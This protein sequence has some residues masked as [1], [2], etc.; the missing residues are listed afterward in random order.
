MLAIALWLWEGNALAQWMIEVV[1]DFVWGEGGAIAASDADVND[2]LKAFWTDPVNKLGLRLDDW[3]RELG[4]QGELILPVFV[5]K[6]DGHVRLGYIPP[7]HVEDIIPDPDNCLIQAA[8]VLKASLG[9]PRKVYKVVRAETWR[10]SPHYGRLMPAEP[11]ERDISGGTGRVYDGSCILA[12]TNK[13]SGARRGRSDLL[14]LI[15]W[16][17]GYDAALFDQLD[18]A[19]LIDSF[20]WDVTLKGADEKVIGDFL[21]KNIK[22]K[23][24]SIR[25]HNEQVE[26]QAVTPDFKAQDKSELF[27][28]L[29][30]HILGSRSIPEHY[31]GSGGEVN[32]ATAKEMGLPTQKRMTRRQNV[33]RE[34]M[35]TLG[36]FAIDQA[37]RYGTLPAAAPRD[38]TVTLPEISMKDTSAITTALTSL[39]AALSM[40]QAQ[41]WLRKA[42]AARL[43]A[44]MA[45]QLGTEINV[46][47]EVAPPGQPD[48]EAMRD[49]DPE[50]VRRLRSRLEDGR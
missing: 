10:A 6:V 7:E 46:D 45:G 33:I 39:S 19:Q 15:D 12:Q 13:L 11:N 9:Q 37:V 40:A 22:P 41:G 27:R 14:A 16:L 32:L 4:L 20:I 36:G 31:Y 43:F 2:V 26:W 30:T 24:G 5:N 38:V 50:K 1:V 29:R 42:T 25:A 17:D 3:T 21:K 34:L 48:E 18:R 35:R 44:V 8:V 23:R 49:Y 28:L 47:E